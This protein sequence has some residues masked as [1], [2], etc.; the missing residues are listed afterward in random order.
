MPVT[1][2]A[3]D[4][5]NKPTL[6]FPNAIL[7]DDFN[8]NYDEN[9]LLSLVPNSFKT[10]AKQLLEVFDERG[11]ELT[12]N[13]SGTVFI[14][15]VSIPQSNFFIIFPFLFKRLKPKRLPGFE[16]V[17]EKINQMGLKELIFKRSFMTK[18]HQL[19]HSNNVTQNNDPEQNVPWWYIGD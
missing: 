3:E 1:A 7:K 16:D 6:P 2:K 8:D 17:V 15:Q 11:N 13:S 12:W 19:V 9:Q 14:D 5:E 18:R 10:K 4:V